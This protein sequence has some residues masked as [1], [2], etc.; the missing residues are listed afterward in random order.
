MKSPREYYKE[1]HPEEFSDSSTEEA[2]DFDREVID[3]AFSLITTNNQ[4]Q[5]FERF[6]LRVCEARVCANLIANTGP[7]GGG[8]GK[9]DADTFP[10][11]D[12]IAKY[13]EGVGRQTTDERWAF[14]FSAKQ[15]WK[16]KLKSD[17]NSILSTKRPYAQIIFVTNQPVPSRERQTVQDDLKNKCGIPV[18]ILDRTWLLDSI[19]YDNCAQFAFEELGF[20]SVKRF[21]VLPGP[22][23]KERRQRLGELRDQLKNDFKNKPTFLSVENALLAAKLARSLEEPQSTVELLFQEARTHAKTIGTDAQRMEVE[24]QLAWTQFW[25]YEDYAAFLSSYQAFINSLGTNPSLEGLSKW[26][27]LWQITSVAIRETKA[28]S[29]LRRTKELSAAI[30]SRIADCTPGSTSEL[31]AQFLKLQF[32]VYLALGKRKLPSETFE[33]VAENLT[34]ATYHLGFDF[35]GFIRWIEV[36]AGVIP[37]DPSFE[38]LYDLATE[39]QASRD[40]EVSAA[41]MQLD[42]AEALIES[43]NVKEAVARLCR[44]HAHLLKHETRNECIHCLFLLGNMYLRLGLTWAARATFI[45]AAAIG[46][47]YLTTENELHP[48]FRISMARLRICS[49]TLGLLGESLT[50]QELTR[51]LQSI[52]YQRTGDSRISPE[53]EIKFEILLG[54]LILR[55][56]ADS[57]AGLESLP[58]VLEELD[59]PIAADLARIKLGADLSTL[60]YMPEPTVGSPLDGI[61]QMQAD[62]LLADAPVDVPVE[63]TNLSTTLFGCRFQFEFENPDASR[64]LVEVLLTL[65]EPIFATAAVGDVL[66]FQEQVVVRVVCSEASESVIELRQLE[67]DPRADFEITHGPVVASALWS[68]P[69]SISQRLVECAFLISLGSFSSEVVMKDLE[70]KSASSPFERSNSL[71]RVT[72]DLKYVVGDLET[73][74]LSDR[75]RKS[76]EVFQISEEKWEPTAVEPKPKKSE[77]KNKESSTSDEEFRK[78]VARLSHSEVT[79]VSPIR[80]AVWDAAGWFGV[81]FAWSPYEPGPPLMAFGFENADA[82]RAIIEGWRQTYGGEL[83]KMLRISII[84]GISKQNPFYYRVLISGQLPSTSSD[85][86]RF[87]QSVSRI[88][89]MQ[90]DSPK[91]LQGFLDMFNYHG[92]YILSSAS[93]NMETPED[94]DAVFASGILMREVVVREA[95]EIGIHDPDGAGVLEGDDVIVPDD[96]ESPPVLELLAWKRDRR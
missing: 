57:R 91:N 2:L 39:L 81:L 93:R 60:D 84:R 89:T 90:A 13:Y 41:K 27:N 26:R 18:T 79:V 68:D 86:A 72:S 88:H 64:H 40:G 16:Q 46:L 77:N 25:W 43:G 52:T 22:R 76:Y 78:A 44:A 30:D 28:S 29:K 19:I 37:A 73:L 87:V 3:H 54:R 47:Q 24:Y 53:E 55:V 56:P 31:N 35:E 59:L 5:A 17:V 8:D 92:K 34:E 50:W 58:S 74:K 36:T 75:L 48:G 65:I 51:S 10:V 38:S 33:T 82:G 23:D 69:A 32:D 70:A 1:Q 83:A 49:V 21:Q 71:S 12:S 20:K 45:A 11:A 63:T 80:G 85:D 15:D 6:C 14:A 94:W 66:A 96:I 42:R 9:V 4:E 62:L 7:A 61:Y 95:W 67:T